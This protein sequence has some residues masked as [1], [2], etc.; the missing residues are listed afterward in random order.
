VLS[1]QKELAGDPRVMGVRCSSPVHD[2]PFDERMFN[3]AIFAAGRVRI[4]GLIGW[5]ILF[6]CLFVLFCFLFFQTGFLCIALAVL[7]LTL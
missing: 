1:G 4:S 6:V 3:T 7:E 2:L 5:L